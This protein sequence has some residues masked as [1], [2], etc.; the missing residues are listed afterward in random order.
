MFNR[1]RNNKKTEDNARWDAMI[2]E[3]LRRTEALRKVLV[4]H[5][6][7]RYTDGAVDELRDK[8]PYA[9][10]ELKPRTDL[11][12]ALNKYAEY[13]AW[14]REKAHSLHWAR[15]KVVIVLDSFDVP[16]EE[17]EKLFALCHEWDVRLFR[18]IGER[19]F[20]DCETGERFRLTLSA[21]YPGVV[22]DAATYQ[23]ISLEPIEDEPS[24]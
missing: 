10:V 18:K 2:A 24:L 12:K 17:Q 20:E 19:T 11:T 6:L 1:F 13:A 23:D 16:E 21:A 3:D 14:A 15:G 8:T 9:W 4:F 22:D 7:E 5:D